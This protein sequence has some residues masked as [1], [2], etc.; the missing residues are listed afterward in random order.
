MSV[1]VLD[2]VVQPG[3]RSARSNV[4]VSVWPVFMTGTEIA[5][6]SSAMTSTGPARSTR[7]GSEIGRLTPRR[8]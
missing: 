1:C 2:V 5:V 3:G 7:Y 6:G 4:N 8:L